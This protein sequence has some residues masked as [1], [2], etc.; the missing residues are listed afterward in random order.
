MI[1]DLWSRPQWTLVPGEGNSSI[2]FMKPRKC[3]SRRPKSSTL[4]LLTLMTNSSERKMYNR[5]RG[6][7]S[8]K[9]E[10]WKAPGPLRQSLSFLSQRKKRKWGR[11]FRSSSDYKNKLMI[12]W[13]RNGV[14]S[15][16][17]QR[18]KTPKRSSISRW[19][20]TTQAVEMYQEC[21]VITR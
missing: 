10:S 9:R 5:Q 21:E 16:K 6:S 11:Y 8:C 20:L 15:C 13:E 4:V 14:N 12:A 2:S 7:K 17:G 19:A 3:S 18:P 1:L